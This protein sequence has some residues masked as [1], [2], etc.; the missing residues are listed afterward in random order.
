MQIENGHW[1][2]KLQTFTS[3]NKGRPARHYEPWNGNS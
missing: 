1:Q 3:A 2:E